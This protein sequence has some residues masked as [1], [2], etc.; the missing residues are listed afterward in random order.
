[1]KLVC[2]RNNTTNVVLLLIEKFPDSIPV[3]LHYNA[4]L[5]ADP[6]MPKCCNSI[7]QADAPA[8]VL[9]MS[10]FVFLIVTQQLTGFELLFNALVQSSL[11]RFDTHQIIISLFDVAG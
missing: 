2:I 4:A 11:I 10:L 9:S 6:L 1:M 5:N 3:S 7:K 8:C